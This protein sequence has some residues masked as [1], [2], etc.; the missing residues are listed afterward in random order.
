MSLSHTSLF[1][2]STWFCST[3]FDCKV[4]KARAELRSTITITSSI[5]K[6]KSNEEASYD[7]SDVFH[8]A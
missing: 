8:F 2:I 4:S 5:N 7:E 3:S 1:E 6:F